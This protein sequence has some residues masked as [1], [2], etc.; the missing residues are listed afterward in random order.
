[1]AGFAVALCA[2]LAA[3]GALAIMNKRHRRPKREIN[4]P[5]DLTVAERRRLYQRLD[6]DPATLARRGRLRAVRP[7][8]TRRTDA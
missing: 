6:L 2:V 8:A 1:M 4:R 5:G 7:D 3:W